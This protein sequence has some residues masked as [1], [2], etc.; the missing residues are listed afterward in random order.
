M[1]ALAGRKVKIVQSLIA[2][3]ESALAKGVVAS[4]GAEDD[5][6]EQQRNGDSGGR[7]QRALAAAR[8][9]HEFERK[10]VQEFLAAKA[11]GCAS[12][13][14]NSVTAPELR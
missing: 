1:S 4:E 9:E 12:V 13:C 14:C 11:A 2:K 5:A 7:A 3:F 8:A 10:F 6:S